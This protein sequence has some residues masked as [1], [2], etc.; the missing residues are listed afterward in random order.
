MGNVGS[1]RRREARMNGVV[2]FVAMILAVVA[3]G[4]AAR[5]I[6]VQTVPVGNPGNAGELPGAGV[7]GTGEDRICGA[8]NYAYRIGTV[9]VTAGQYV[10][11]LNAVAVTDS[12]GLYHSA[13]D[14]DLFGCQITQHGVS[15]GY[16][17]DFSGGGVLSGSKTRKRVYLETT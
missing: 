11:F 7:G 14:S 5:A 12:Y 6:D 17:Y 16:W 9:E 8:V 1:I 4:S 3:C 10:E 15:G 13:M 2:R